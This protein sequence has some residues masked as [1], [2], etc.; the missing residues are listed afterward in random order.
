M[1]PAIPFGTTVATITADDMVRLVGTGLDRPLGIITFPPE[2][3]Q[4]CQVA[5]PRCSAVQDV[6]KLPADCQECGRRFHKTGPIR[7]MPR[8]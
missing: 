7:R 4:L 6:E 5:C 8:S 3:P 2:K 1:A